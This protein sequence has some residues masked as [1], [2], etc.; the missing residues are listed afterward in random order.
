LIYKGNEDWP[1]EAQNSQ[2]DSD[3]EFFCDLCAFCG[4]MVGGWF[5][6]GMGLADHQ[7]EQGGGQG[8]EHGRLDEFTAIG[9]R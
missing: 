9:G 3:L 8:S 5:W 6:F 2:R 7:E 1:Q 4:W